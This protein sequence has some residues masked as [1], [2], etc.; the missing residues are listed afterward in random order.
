MSDDLPGPV[1]RIYFSQRLRLH[2]VDWG[3]EAAPPLILLHGGRDHCRSWDYVAKALRGDF[4]VIAPDLRGHGDSQWSASGHYPMASYIYDLAQLIHSQKLAP[5]SIVAH[6]LGGNI[7]LRYTGIYPDSVRRL[8]A[9]EGL[10]PGPRGAGERDKK[11]IH[12]RMATWITEQR[13][14]SSE[15]PWRYPSIEA[16]LKRMQE[17]NKRLS[18]EIARHLTEHAVNQNEDGTYCWKFDPYVRVWPPNDMTREEIA[19][20][21]ARI[22][23]PTLLVWGKESWATNPAED[24]RLDYFRDGRVLGVDGAGHW[25]HHDRL[26]LFVDETRKFLLA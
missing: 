26:A 4:H 19:S 7:A 5:V 12:E 2:Y 13:A 18:A 17:A 22:T 6:S 20:L 24:G 11:P 23:C 9:I 21:W 8:V 25:V 1:S 3:N 15:V 10:G 16:A 14:Q